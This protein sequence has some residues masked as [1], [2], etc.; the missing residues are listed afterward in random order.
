MNLIEKVKS[1]DRVYSW[2]FHGFLLA[3]IFGGVSI[4][5]G[6]Y[7]DDKPDLNFVVISDSSVFDVKEKIGLL[8]IIYDGKSLSKSNQ[9]LKAIV[10]N[11]VN[12]G[13]GSV[14]KSYYDEAD[15]V[16][17]VIENGVLA[18]Q[19]SLVYAS[20][21]YLEKALDIKKVGGDKIEF[22]NVIIDKGQS[23]S[24]KLL[25]L[26]DSG[27]APKI[28]PI[29]KIANIETLDLLINNAKGESSLS[30]EA[31]FS[32][33]VK[34]IVSRTLVYGPLFLILVIGIFG[35]V[36][37]VYEWSK[38]YKRGRVVAVYRKYNKLLLEKKDDAI[39]DAY[40]KYGVTQ[41]LIVGFIL[42]SEILP[43]MP[44][45]VHFLE[46]EYKKRVIDALESLIDSK[47]VTV[48]GREIQADEGKVEV[49]N[50]FF[51][52]LKKN[53]EVT[54]MTGLRWFNIEIDPDAAGRGLVVN[55]KKSVEK[56][57]KS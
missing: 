57:S 3:V 30:S 25:V 46:N 49:F 38:R 29:G 9:E 45:G 4:Y 36:V 34:T 17:L 16:G 15:P 56:V 55:F 14:L 19:P 13:R 44:R 8:D 51:R 43:T 54:D 18:A 28:I 40:K 33:S 32:S 12:Q 23:F 2:S 35:G 50:S 41:L 53:G 47:L 31:V 5:T 6:F 10:V 24:I 39:L 37:Q 20:N 27:V 42:K 1:L 21:N 52:Y 26:H 7:K 22:S 11:V 48:S